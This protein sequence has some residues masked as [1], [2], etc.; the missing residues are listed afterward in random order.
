[1]VKKGH[2]KGQSDNRQQENQPELLDLDIAM[3][4][5]NLK[6]TPAERIRRHQI[7]LNTV[8]KLRK[9]EQI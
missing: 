8:K 6:R 4:K 9:A 7:A 3:L 1:M 2:S 5:E